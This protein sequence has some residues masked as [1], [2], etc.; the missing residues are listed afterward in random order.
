MEGSTRDCGEGWRVM[1]T[2]LECSHAVTAVDFAPTTSPDKRSIQEHVSQEYT[3]KMLESVHSTCML[4]LHHDRRFCYRE[5]FQSLSALMKTGI[6]F[7]QLP[8]G[9]HFSS[10]CG[11][12]VWA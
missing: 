12:W 7:N 10:W 6:F 9:R 8:N 2:P 11:L 3:S 1:S 4:N 5:G